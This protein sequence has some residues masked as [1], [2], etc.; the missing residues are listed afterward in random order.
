[1]SEAFENISRSSRY[2]NSQPEP[3]LDLVDGRCSSPV[4]CFGWGY[5]RDRNFGPGV[6]AT[7]PDTV[8]KFRV[9]AQPMVRAP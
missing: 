2:V 4:A 6:D 7:N 8:A 3:C 5:C 1:M 9:L